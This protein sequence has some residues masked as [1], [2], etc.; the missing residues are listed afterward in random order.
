MGPGFLNQVPTL[1]EF[2]NK[3]GF[4]G[5]GFG[6]HLN[7]DLDLQFSGQSLPLMSSTG[8]ASCFF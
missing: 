7:L 3:V 8:R 1:V 2:F 4:Q 6:I 5:L